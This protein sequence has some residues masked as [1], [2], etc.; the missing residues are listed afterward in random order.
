MKAIKALSIA[1]F[2]L[3]TASFSFGQSSFEG[4]IEYKTTNAALKEAATVTWYHKNGNNL[5]EFDSKAGEYQMNYSLIMGSND[6]S[7]YMKSD[8]G[9]QEISGITSEE[10]F[11]N[12]NF[13]RKMDVKESGYAFEMLM[14]RSN[15]QELVY[16]MTSDVGPSYS[17]LPK[18]MR[19][20]MPDMTGISNGFPVK[21][22]LRDNDGNLL[23]SQNLVS[24]KATSVDDSKFIK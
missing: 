11:T 16:W 20:N 5:M 17:N 18:L 2:F 23:R 6:A 10:I 14:F 9:G 8:K 1:L 22:E 13:V 3:L 21:M 15:G 7:V 4:V 24:A 12:A 19:N